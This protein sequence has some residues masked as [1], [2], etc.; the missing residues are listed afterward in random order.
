MPNARPDDLETLA[1]VDAVTGALT[2]LGHTVMSAPFHS[3]RERL[4]EAIW[5]AQPALLFNLVETFWG[6]TAF[7]PFALEM[8]EG[9][10]LPVTG[11]GSA[12]MDRTGDKVQAKS[13]LTRAGL[14]TP[15]WS[16]GP[17]WQGLETGKKWIVKCADEDASLGLDDESIVASREAISA[18]AKLCTERYG[19]HW[20]AEEFIEGRE[21]NVGILERGGAPEI[22]PIAEMRF[23][24]WD[25]KRP[26]IVG[27][28]AKWNEAD[29]DFANT[30]RSFDWRK[31]EPKLNE[32]LA[33]LA[34]CC[35]ALFA[36]RGYA[37][38]DFRVNA[39]G[40][41]Y[42]LEINANPSLEPEAGFAIAARE[43]GMSYDKL[44][45]HICNTA[46]DAAPQELPRDRKTRRR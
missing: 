25:P 21:F 44:I 30:V 20:F 6:R 7:A 41:P 33:E 22:L 31:N 38:V 43:A 12:S 42:I 37:R 29:T 35:W 23:E 10:G 27:Y 19:G 1:Q 46:I 4:A 11:A 36:C 34:Q 8:M 45:E 39:S 3:D 9:T 16:Q 26:K 13:I 18:R 24:H 5:N 2:R 15:S 32:N 40:K 14:P 28:N 17:F